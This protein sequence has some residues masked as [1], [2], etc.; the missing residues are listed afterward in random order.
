MVDSEPGRGLVTA[1]VVL[2]RVLDASQSPYPKMTFGTMTLLRQGHKRT[3]Q[4]V[5]VGDE[6][7]LDL[8]IEIYA[9]EKGSTD[10]TAGGPPDLSPD[11][12]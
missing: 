12:S 8:R 6:S 9:I 3:V 7:G 2:D 1:K 5:Q 11:L 10:D 4:F